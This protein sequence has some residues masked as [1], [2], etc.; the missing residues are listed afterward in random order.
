MGGF[1]IFIVVEIQFFS[2][3]VS[4]FFGFVEIGESGFLVFGRIG[5]G[6]SVSYFCCFVRFLVVL[7]LG[8]LGS[9]FFALIHLWCGWAWKNDTGSVMDRRTD[10][11]S[12]VFS[13]FGFTVFRKYGFSVLW[14]CLCAD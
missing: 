6:D 13:F 2:F 4:W 12:A 3:V 14:V 10:F 11:G 9:L 8:K 7:G 1:F 5:Y